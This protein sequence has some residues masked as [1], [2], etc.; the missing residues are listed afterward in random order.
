RDFPASTRL[1]KT[2]PL[3]ASATPPGAVAWM[4]AAV[5]GVTVVTLALRSA[6]SSR[7]SKV[8][9]YLRA[10]RGRRRWITVG[11]LTRGSIRS[12]RQGARDAG[13]PGDGLGTG[14]C[15]KAA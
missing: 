5:A 8:G 7:R 11:L 12:G 10:G 15:G 4:R 1:T 2:L 14:R 13:F 9:R 3:A 6:R